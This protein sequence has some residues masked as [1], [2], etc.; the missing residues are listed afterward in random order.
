MAILVTGATGLV[1]R[2][3]LKELT[4]PAY[5][6]SRSG[7]ILDGIDG[8]VTGIHLDLTDQSTIDELPW[9][10]IDDVV[11]LGAYTDPRRSV[12]N[13]HLC[14]QT[15]ASGTSALLT[16][17]ADAGVGSFVYTSSYWVY[18]PSVTGKVDESTPLRTETP[19]GA[20]KAAA[21][22]QCEAFRSQFDF[23]VTTLRPFNVYG[24]GARQHQVIPE[25]V[26]QAVEEGL[27][28]PHP[29][30]PV[31]DFLYVDDLVDGIQ[32]CT[33]ERTDTVFNIG[34]GS[35]TSIRQ[36]ATAVGDVVEQYTGTHVE[37]NFTDNYNQTDK[38]VADTTKLRAAV[39]WESNTSLHDGIDSVVA[40]YL[41]THNVENT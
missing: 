27:I 36:L 29:G 1:G 26:Q 19:Y 41:T 3:L 34:T 22:F 10:D 38:K 20:S 39:D 7:S 28:E 23:A 37:K 2:R 30:N 35:G 24:P 15:N 11:H 21:E 32:A 4:V 40:H 17:A 14:F 12:D 25:F 9:E 5:A 6:A 13:P 31:R 33:A 18:D 16:A 8:D